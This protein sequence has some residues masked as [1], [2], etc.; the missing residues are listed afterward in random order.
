LLTATD[1]TVDARFFRM[2]GLPDITD[3]R[4]ESARDLRAF[5]GRLILK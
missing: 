1:E 5:D 4:L 3:H 2:D